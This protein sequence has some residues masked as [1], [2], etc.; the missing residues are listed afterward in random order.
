ME[1]TF[2][3]SAWVPNPS[4]ATYLACSIELSESLY[5]RAG[6]ELGFWISPVLLFISIILLWTARGATTRE[7]SVNLFYNI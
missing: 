3:A 4:K 5:L 2:P 1:T 7:K 6:P